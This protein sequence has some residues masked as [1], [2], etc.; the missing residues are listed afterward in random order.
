MR[1]LHGLDRPPAGQETGEC[2]A[3]TQVAAGGLTALQRLSN[4]SPT[5]LARVTTRLSP[6]C[7]A[8]AGQL[9]PASDPC[10]LTVKFAFLPRSYRVPTAILPPSCRGPTWIT[11]TIV[12][13]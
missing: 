4:G 9:K 10:W 8:R 1:E 13:P 2:E 12:V 3:G 11:D 5:A 7:Q 6:R